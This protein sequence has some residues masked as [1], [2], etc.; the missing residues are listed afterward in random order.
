V[1]FC[2]V[3]EFRFKGKVTQIP[4]DSICFYMETG[5]KNSV[6]KWPGFYFGN[7]IYAIK[8]AP[9]Q[10]EV[11]NYKFIGADT[12]FPM[13]QGQIMITNNWPSKPNTTDYKLGTNWYTDSAKPDNY[14]G[15]IQGGKTIA[16]WRHEALADWA[17]RWAWLK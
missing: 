1:A 17:K 13:K 6:Q 9:K 2:S 4:K 11:L 16:K 10:A 12:Y 7:G 15:K 8:Y 14:D 3:L 5:Y